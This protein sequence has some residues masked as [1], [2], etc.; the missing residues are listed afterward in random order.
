MATPLTTP[1]QAGGQTVTYRLSRLSLLRKLD[2]AHT[3][4]SNR[5]PQ[6]PLSRVGG[7]D[8][9]SAPWLGGLGPRPRSIGGY[10]V[11]GHG[12]SCGCVRRIALMASPCGLGARWCRDSPIPR[13]A[14]TGGWT[15]GQIGLLKVTTA[16]VGKVGRLLRGARVRMRHR[17]AARRA[18]RRR[19]RAMRAVRG[20]V[21]GLRTAGRGLGA[22]HGGR[23]RCSR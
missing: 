2:F 20:A 14:A 16:D 17:V 18:C 10:A 4:C 15:A 1:H 13:L 23:R 8:A 6:N 21:R 11:D 12:G 9:R 5:L 7:I 22:H 19:L 3:A